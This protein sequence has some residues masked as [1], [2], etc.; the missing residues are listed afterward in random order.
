MLGEIKEKKYAEPLKIAVMALANVSCETLK[1]LKF[2]MKQNK[3]VEFTKL[4][5]SEYNTYRCIIFAAKTNLLAIGKYYT[6]E[7]D[8]LAQDFVK[9]IDDA[10][11]IHEIDT[12][13]EQID[14]TFIEQKF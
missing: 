3:T 13:R 10:R 7:T 14:K 6:E 5:E 11:F 8:R 9:Q 1:A 12:V 2:F 4:S